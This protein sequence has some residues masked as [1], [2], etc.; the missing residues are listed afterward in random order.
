VRTIYVAISL[1]ATLAE[2]RARRRPRRH[3]F[4]PIAGGLF[5]VSPDVFP[6][7][8]RRQGVFAGRLRHG[9]RACEAHQLV[10]GLGF[11][12]EHCLKDWSPVG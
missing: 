5:S 11:V 4:C 3:Y 6:S 12:G 9:E 10:V 1:N 2:R 7:V 8:R